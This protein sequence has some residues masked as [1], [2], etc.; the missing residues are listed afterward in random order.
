MGLALAAVLAVGVAA[1]GSGDA[2]ADT[3]GE[4][5]SGYVW[6][7][8]NAPAPTVP[9]EWIDATDGTVIPGTD[10]DDCADTVDLPFAFSFFGTDYTQVAISTNGI[11][12]F[13]LEDPEECNDNYNWDETQGSDLGN[14]IPYTDEDCAGTSGWGNNPIIAS[15]FDDLDPGECGDVY[16]ETFG[17]APNRAFVVQFDEVCHDDCYGSCAESQGIT[18]ETILNE[19][20]NDIKVQYLDTVFEADTFEDLEEENFGGTATTGISGDG[21]VGLGYSWAGTPP[22]TGNLAVLYTTSLPD[23]SP[24]PSPTP[25]RQTRPRRPAP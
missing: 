2:N 18:F 7:D 24:T 8:S 5:P 14:P 12:S 20:T 13:D 10:C 25:R 15:W 9:F 4:N 6:I 16:H 23:P 22:L 21:S 1:G 17:S 3:S 19:T 11:I